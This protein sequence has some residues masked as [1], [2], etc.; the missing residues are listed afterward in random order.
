MPATKKKSPASVSRHPL[1]TT[2]RGEHDEVRKFFK[3]FEKEKNAPEEAHTAAMTILG[4]LIGHAEREESIFYPALKERDEKL[5]HE[6]HEEHRVAKQLIAELQQ[7]DPD[8]TFNAKMKVLNDVIEHHIEEEY[9][10]VFPAMRGLLRE[11]LDEMAE[12]WS[13]AKLGRVPT[14]VREGT[15]RRRSA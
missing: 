6:A 7:G 14:A 9:E 15:R 10:Q 13:A 11:Q 3:Q 5:F 12:R 2:I 4:E 8:E 1:F